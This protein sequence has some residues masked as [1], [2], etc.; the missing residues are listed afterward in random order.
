MNEENI[1]YTEEY[2]KFNDITILKNI[3]NTMNNDSII[4][5]K[6]LPEIKQV[7]SYILN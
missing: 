4:N 5:S 6:K 3:N 2:F 1:R 7:I